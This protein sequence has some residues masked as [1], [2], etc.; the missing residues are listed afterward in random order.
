MTQRGV[1]WLSR[2]GRAYRLFRSA[3]NRAILTSKGLRSVALSSYIHRTSTV[4]RDLCAGDY[5]FIGPACSIPPLVSIG[6][7]TMLAARVAIVGDDH[8]FDDPAVPMQFT[9]RPS[10]RATS[11]GSD[12][13]IGHGAVVMRGLDIGDGALIAA[14]SVVTHDVPAREV[15]AGVPARKLR[16]RFSDDQQCASHEQMLSSPLLEPHFVEP[17]LW[18]AAS[19]SDTLRGRESAGARPP[20][21][22]AP[23]SASPAPGS[24]LS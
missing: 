21:T 22:S 17:Q 10:Q 24:R 7:Y 4:A 2:N 13:W 19:K 11:I 8:R 3:R 6:R 18:L 9:G 14:G 20:T 5:V 16:D 15:W 23:R 12:V 1:P